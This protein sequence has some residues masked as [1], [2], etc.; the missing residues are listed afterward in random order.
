M[1]EAQGDISIQGGTFENTGVQV[2]SATLLDPQTEHYST[3]LPIAPEMLGEPRV[4]TGRAG[5]SYS[6]HDARYWRALYDN[7]FVRC[8]RRRYGRRRKCFVSVNPRLSVGLISLCEA[9]QV[10]LGRFGCAAG[11]DLYGV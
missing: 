8:Y 11:V 3:E 4:L 6:L 1:A 9:F 5:I 10:L 2:G 7:A